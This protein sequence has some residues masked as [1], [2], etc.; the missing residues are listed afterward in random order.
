VDFTLPSR[1]LICSSHLTLP[2]PLRLRLLDK[3]EM[4]ALKFPILC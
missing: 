3:E 4:G 1:I 2:C